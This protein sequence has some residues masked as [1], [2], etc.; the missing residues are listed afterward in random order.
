MKLLILLLFS[1]ALSVASNS[2]ENE[3][4]E[5][6]IV[7]GSDAAPEQFPFLVSMRWTADRTHFCKLH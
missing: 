5:H 7:G 1:I 4:F 6:F 3:D 2:S